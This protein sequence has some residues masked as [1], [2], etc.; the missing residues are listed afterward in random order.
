[1]GGEL[2]P[3]RHL[4]AQI[5]VGRQLV[6]AILEVLHHADVSRDTRRLDSLD[7]GIGDIAEVAGLARLGPGRGVD[8]VLEA[9]WIEVEAE[10]VDS[11]F[12]GRVVDGA[13]IP[14]LDQS[15][16]T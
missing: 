14:V 11:P 4:R 6:E 13:A 9:A 1:M 12:P 5:T 16:R 7:V 10:D 8:T 3:V 2:L 15:E